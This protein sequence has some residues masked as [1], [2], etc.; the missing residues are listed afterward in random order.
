MNFIRTVCASILPIFLMTSVIQAAINNGEDVTHP[1][2]RFDT[3]LK[4]QNGVDKVDGSD[5][6]GTARTDI[7]LKF[8]NEWQLAFRAD[9][10][11]ESFFCSKHCQ[12]CGGKNAKHVGD[13][14][15]Q[16]L[17]V[18]PP[19]GDW[20]FA[21]GEQTIFPTAGDNLNIGDAK[22][23][24]LPTVAAR[25][26][27]GY[28][29]DGAYTGILLRHAFSVGGYPSAPPVART[30]IQPTLNI[31]FTKGWFINSSPELRYNWITSAWFVPFDLMIGVMVTPKFILSIEY[32]KA[33][34]YDYPEYNQELEIRAGIFF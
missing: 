24:L 13:S 30:Y 15:F 4:C 11:I 18:T 5:I 27:L 20:L 23:Q 8:D 2:T 1:V 21:I 17:F 16:F 9:F 33:I 26:D 34:V 28:W 31:N 7:V 3:R 19:Q 29:S 14:L 12:E 32:A 25:Y 6:I 22:Y 10:P